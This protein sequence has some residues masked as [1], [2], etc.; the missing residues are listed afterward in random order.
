MSRRSYSSPLRAAQADDTRERIFA[1][2]AALLSEAGAAEISIDQIAERATVQRRTV[3]RHFENREALFAAFWVWLNARLA[4]VTEPAD[5]DELIK[6]PLRAFPAFDEEAGVIRASLHTPS[7]RAM[8][9]QTVA[10]RR[11]AF[12]QALSP[13]TRNLAAA[14]RARIEGLAHLLYSASAWEAL[15]DY[16]GLTG[17]QAGE[18]AS[19]A[20]RLILSAIGQ[21][22][23]PRRTSHP[24]EG[25]TS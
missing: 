12:S 22:E 15:T 1:A 7:G 2:T 14:D 3:F 13:V 24:I 25:S 8:R 11:A 5:A 9:A 10:A 21:G 4:L 17:T 23:D 19:W 16:G 6:G 20:L 18:A